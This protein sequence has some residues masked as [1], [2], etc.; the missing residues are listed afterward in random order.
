MGGDRP[1]SPTELFAQHAFSM[2]A[3]ATLLDRIA[4]LE[5]ALEKAQV[6]AAQKPAEEELIALVA[7]LKASRDTLHAKASAAEAKVAELDH[8]AELL[9]KRLES[10]R[11]EA[12]RAKDRADLLQLEVEGLEEEVGALKREKGSWET[13]RKGWKKELIALEERVEE[14]RAERDNACTALDAANASQQSRRVGGMG[15]I[16]ASSTATTLFEAGDESFESCPLSAVSSTSGAPFKFKDQGEPRL[17]AVVEEE[18]DEVNNSINQSTGPLQA[19]FAANFAGDVAYSDDLDDDND[20][21]GDHGSYEDEPAGFDAF[22]QH[23]MEGDDDSDRSSELE[24]SGPTPTSS[25]MAAPAPAQQRS[26]AASHS[27]RASL[28]ANWR[29]PAGAAATTALTHKQAS[30]HADPFL[31]TD[32]DVMDDYDDAPRVAF[33]GGTPKRPSKKSQ[34]RVEVTPQ[35]ADSFAMNFA[36]EEDEGFS[37]GE[38]LAKPQ[39]K[40]DVKIGHLPR[41]SDPLCPPIHVMGKTLYKLP[42]II[43]LI[44]KDDS[45]LTSASSPTSTTTTSTTASSTPAV[46]PTTPIKPKSR[47]LS[48]VRPEVTPPAFI[49]PPTFNI[50]TPSASTSSVCPVPPSPAALKPPSS[51]P[52][53][54]L[55]AVSQSSDVSTSFFSSFASASTSTNAS[56]TTTGDESFS[57]SYSASPVKPPSGLSGAE[58]KNV[59]AFPTTSS[60]PFA[61]RSPVSVISSTLASFIP[62]SPRRPTTPTSPKSPSPTPFPSLPMTVED[63][64]PQSQKQPMGSVRGTKTRAGTVSADVMRERLRARLV[65]EG[66]IKS[67]MSPTAISARSSLPKGGVPPPGR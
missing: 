62:W 24:Q 3:H 33:I 61:I 9:Q 29:F 22:I 31:V 56:T 8:A 51:S 50:C 65:Q 15:N 60:S 19:S 1:V 44:P 67:S 37:W 54:L 53:S 6:Q 41:L 11:Q 20:D 43:P 4:T 46:A 17:G 49:P 34:T 57:F 66:K 5:E 63:L 38:E 59:V 18:E 45:V 27:R 25:L 2:Q 55:L 23:A 7:D 26:R 52:A 58:E 64:Q 10:A 39:T 14:L 40:E 35:L 30:A 12:R 13:E 36:A 28:V 47:I 21:E 42:S 16:S 48:Q 32:E